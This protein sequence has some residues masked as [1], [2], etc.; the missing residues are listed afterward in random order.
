[1]S[2]KEESKIPNLPNPAKEELEKWD[3]IL[4]DYENSVGLPAFLSEYRNIEATE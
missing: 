2:G 3:K 1:M 4:D